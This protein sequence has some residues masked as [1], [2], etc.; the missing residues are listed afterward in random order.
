[1]VKHLGEIN[2][3]FTFI[4]INQWM[5]TVNLEP[6]KHK[7]N[8][9]LITIKKTVETIRLEVGKQE[10]TS[11]P[12][13]RYLAVILDAPLN[14][15]QPVEHVSSKASVMKASLARSMPNVVVPKQSRRLLLL[16]MVTSVLT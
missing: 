8:V 2:L 3:T 1:M 6:V 12:F 10:I 9:V 7:T 16:S 15:K 5:D 14:F 4:R 11:K 13:I